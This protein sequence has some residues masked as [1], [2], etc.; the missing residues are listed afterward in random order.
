MNLF[1]FALLGIVTGGALT[2]FMY[3]RPVLGG[4]IHSISTAAGCLLGLFALYSARAD[5]GALSWS[6]PWLHT[7][8]LSFR[9]DNLSAFFLL[10]VFCVC[11]LAVLYAFHYFDRDK[12]SLRIA[13]N[14][15]FTSLL[16]VSMALVSVAGNILTFALCWEVMSI[17][18]YFL[19]LHDFHKPTTR[20]AGY[21]Y[22]VFAQGGALLIFSAFGLMC[23]QSGSL[24]LALPVH[25][26]ETIKLAIFLLA[27]VGF[28]SK[29]GV[30]PFHI[31]LPK[32]HPAAP[33][34]I[35][36]IMSAVMI[37]M[38]IYGILRVYCILGPTSA[39]FGQL[40]L[41]FGIASGI[42]G[43]LYALGKNDLKKLLAYSSVENIGIVLMGVGLGMI[44]TAAHNP[45]MA[46]FGF[47]G[48][49]LH[50]LNHSIFKSLLF[51][52]AGAVIK[53]NGKSRIDMLGGVLKRM[54]VVGKTFLLGSVAI[55]GLPPLNGFIS[56][57]LLYV[58]A[59]EGLKL[60]H[61]S[62]LLAIAA[63]FALAII[64]GLASAC[65][66][67]VVG[68]VFLGEP[69]SDLPAPGRKPGAAML[70]PMVGLATACVAIGL[71]PE[72]FVAL[73]SWG[74]RAIAGFPATAAALTEPFAT[75]L[76]FAARLFLGV[77]IF[78]ALARKLLYR[79]KVLAQGPTWGCGFSRPTSRIQY[80]GPSY[81]RSAISFF[82]PFAL[83]KETAVTLRGI[84]AEEPVFHQRVD[85][86]AEVGL[87]RGFVR[88]LL[89]LLRKLRWIQH[90]NIQLYIG[91]IIGIVLILACITLI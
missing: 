65:F 46:A 5:L 83:V 22:F 75:H 39:L 84:F 63:I 47:T 1:F 90:G 17:S 10:P 61:S 49:L 23:S 20:K 62:L 16:I 4:Y 66:T 59:F 8:I 71:F 88:P 72:P 28:G 89:A 29:A 50:V 54:P 36:A 82:R 37:K 43:V 40:T 48:A 2:L 3:R 52:G 70:V 32:A 18:S 9:F 79:G 87:A 7:F 14:S 15:F 78:L 53:Q 64:G 19:V 6:L 33:S 86:I 76:A 41:A 21:L 69:R 77:L 42:L 12:S 81:A 85:D 27:L 13:V 73:A 91:Y 56:E 67:K 51:L 74:C 45:A 58:A 24:A 25:T 30:Y 35:S 11:P 55:S 34:H 60:D 38:G 68:I 57:F 44:G 31:W 80:T 26:P